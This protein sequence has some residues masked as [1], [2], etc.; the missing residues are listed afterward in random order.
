[1]S[2]TTGGLSSSEDVFCT[3][4]AHIDGCP[5][6]AGGDHEL[7]PLEFMTLGTAGDERI[8]FE[9]PKPGTNGI[10]LALKDG[11]VITIGDLGNGPVI[12][13]EGPDAET[14]ARWPMP[15]AENGSPCTLDGCASY[16]GHPGQ[17]FAE[18][19]EVPA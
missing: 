17:H 15:T 4:P 6:K 13:V 9:F 8:Y 12:E 5:G 18:P 16:A 3:D 2:M 14:L 7:R 11:R 10:V 1:M 19:T